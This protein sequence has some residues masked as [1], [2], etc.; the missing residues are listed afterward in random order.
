MIKNN[1][2]YCQCGCGKLAPIA[3]KTNSKFNHIKGQPIRFIQGHQNRGS[4]HPNWKG[5]KKSKQGY[6][7]IWKPNHSRADSDGYV[8][9]HILVAEKVLGKPLPNSAVIHHVNENRSDNRK[10][11][12]VICENNAY[13]LFLHRRLHALKV[14][15]HTNWRKCKY[16]KKY[17]DP[18]NLTISKYNHVFHRKC[19]AKH[20]RL[21][22]KKIRNQKN[23]L[24]D[25][26]VSRL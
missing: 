14:C 11:N 9:E 5:G 25:R 1:P 6:V 12:L 10:E 21:R 20:E 4:M 3:I 8:Y 13:H 17:D 24:H 15:G 23:A 2:G 16:C 19:N 7:R 18:K 26:N 22:R